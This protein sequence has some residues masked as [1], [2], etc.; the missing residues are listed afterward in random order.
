MDNGQL[1]TVILIAIIGNIAL[2]SF[3]VLPLIRRRR[4]PRPTSRNEAATP[5]AAPPPK[6]DQAT[7][8]A[9][10]DLPADIVPIPTAEFSQP[11]DSGDQEP[12]MD[13]TD[14]EPARPPRWA[15]PPDD[16]RADDAIEAFLSDVRRASI[17]VE[18]AA[19]DVLPA[20]GDARSGAAAGERPENATTADPRPDHRPDEPAES[21]PRPGDRGPDPAA[22]ADPV[23]GLDG[24]AAWSHAVTQEAARSSRY[25]RPVAIVIAELDGLD[26]LEERFGAAAADRL[27]PPVADVLR[28]SAR[29]ADT[30]A[31]LDRV[32]FGLLLPETD[33]IQAINLVERIRAGCDRWL[34]AGAVAVRLS[35]GWASPPVGGDLGDALREAEERMHREQRRPAA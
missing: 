30:I 33:E 26:R 20:P 19:P 3:I 34:A 29:S 16:D 14:N 11:P 13:R 9:D 15:L 27:I 23:T 1:S 6:I 35:I 18:P 32:R 17:E 5:P 7:D 25:G 22:L 24:P 2:M 12:N 31:R 28:R 8:T 4:S 21:R 10:A